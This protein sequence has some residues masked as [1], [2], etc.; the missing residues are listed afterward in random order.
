MTDPN[1]T[2]ITVILDRSGSMEPINKDTCGGLNTFI[3]EQRKAPG[4]AT[5][6]LVRFNGTYEMDY[7]DKPIADVKPIASLYP[8]GGTALYDAIGKT[9]DELGGRL[10]RLPEAE[11]PGKVVVVIVTD[12]EEN[13]SKSFT[14]EQVRS[15]VEHQ[16]H[17]YNWQFVFLGANQDAIT[18]AKQ[19]GISA[20]NSADF[21]ASNSRMAFMETSSNLSGYRSL[22]GDNVQLCAYS[23]QQR[24]SLVADA[25]EQQQPGGFFSLQQTGAA[26][27]PRNV[28]DLIDWYKGM[29]DLKAAGDL[30]AL[31][32]AGKLTMTEPLVDFSAGNP[33]CI[34]KA[35][36]IVCAAGGVTA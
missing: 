22:R 16:R 27:E 25:P 36:G 21:S 29:G 12:G 13:A 18:N 9:I 7:L 20:A 15:R 17:V 35:G 28:G 3:E 26:P 10:S 19:L 4:R 6:T 24:H 33:N 34:A 32:T 11:R 30:G 2:A 8:M 31:V 5:M 14:A 23:A 1:L